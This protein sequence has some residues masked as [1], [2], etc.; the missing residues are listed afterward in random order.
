MLAWLGCFACSAR[1]SA[2]PA[3]IALEEPH[4]VQAA[5]G[6]TAEPDSALI[7]SGSDPAAPGGPTDGFVYSREPRGQEAGEG[8]HL[9]IHINESWWAFRAQ[10][11]GITEAEAQ[12]RDA[13]LSRVRAPADFWDAQTSIE[14]VSV[15]SVLCNE[16]H[17]GRRSVEDAREM[18]EPA[19]AWGD[20][21]GLFFGNRRS[22]RH[23]FDVV[24]GGGPKRE[25]GRAEMPAWRNILPTEMRWALLYFLEYQSG[26]I[27]S[28]FPPSLYPR[29]PKVLGQP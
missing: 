8:A 14:A 4:E 25:A 20:G 15:W 21:E 2:A 1:Q 19:P 11:L 18:P 7:A 28:R 24:E 17:G 29:R 10:F 26:G 6:T 9:P 3:G 12:K 13:A 22:Y 23:M 5:G 27:E 16:C